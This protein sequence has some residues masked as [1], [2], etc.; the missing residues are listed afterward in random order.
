MFSFN[1]I[2]SMDFTMKIMEFL[3]SGMTPSQPPAEKELSESIEYVTQ[4]ST[5]AVKLYFI[6][7][8]QI[9]YQMYLL[10]L[11]FFQPSRKVS[12]ISV[13]ET[14]KNKEVTKVPTKE[15]NK[16]GA[17]TINLKVEKPDIILVE[18]MD[19]K[20]CQA[21]MLNVCI[22]Y[23]LLKHASMGMLPKKFYCWKHIWNFHTII[24][25]KIPIK[26]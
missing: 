9:N 18:S 4:S 20:D 25:N 21:L 11:Y 19:N 23:I 24:S 2:L 14:Q 10:N 15:E 5:S 7:N 13:P 1:L 3:T 12:K 26:N 8:I 6:L 22:F 17:I 16:S